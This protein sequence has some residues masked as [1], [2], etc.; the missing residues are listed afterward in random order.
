[1]NETCAEAGVNVTYELILTSLR[2]GMGQ[3]VTKLDDKAWWWANFQEA[4]RSMYVKS[5]IITCTLCI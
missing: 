5:E 3:S 2:K 1:M 4:L